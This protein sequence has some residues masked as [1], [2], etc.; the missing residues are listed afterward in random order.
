M[1]Q[2]L[3]QGEKLYWLGNQAR[4]RNIIEVE[5][6]IIND[7]FQIVVHIQTFQI[8]QSFVFFESYQD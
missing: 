2:A 7:H 3:T 1:N 6:L 5:E 4:S 8:F